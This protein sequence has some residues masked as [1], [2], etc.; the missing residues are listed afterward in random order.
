MSM[1]ENVSRLWLESQRQRSKSGSRT[2]E[3]NIDARRKSKLTTITITLTPFPLVS[4]RWKPKRAIITITH[5]PYRVSTGRLIPTY[6]CPP[7]LHTTICTGPLLISYRTPSRTVRYTPITRHTL[8]FHLL[9][10]TTPHPT[11]HLQIALQD[12]LVSL[13]PTRL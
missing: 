6:P 1:H 13:D 11:C 7:T 12:R 10:H 8:R 9:F 3:R 4:C 2:E 5:H